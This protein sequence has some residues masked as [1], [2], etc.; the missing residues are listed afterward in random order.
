MTCGGEED[1]YHVNLEKDK[2]LI[3][4]FL[5]S[6]RGQHIIFI[7]DSLMRFQVFSLLY[8]IKYLHFMTED[9][10][11]NPMYRHGYATNHDFFV[12]STALFGP[13]SH[14]DC[15]KSEVYWQ[16]P[17]ENRYYYDYNYNFN[18]T[19]L[20]F[21]GEMEA[22]GHWSD[23][24]D[25]DH[26]RSPRESY[27]NPFWKKHLEAFFPHVAS[28]WIIP[29]T[30]TVFNVGIH[31]TD[32][33][34][35]KKW[36][37]YEYARMIVEAAQKHGPRFIFRTTTYNQNH[38][39]KGKEFEHFERDHLFCSMKGVKCQNVSWTRCIPIKDYI[40]DF[41]YIVEPYNRMA[42]QFMHL[43]LHYDYVS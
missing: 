18:I 27:L 14:C 17:L 21:Y 5:E 13:N 20:L 35:T 43:W 34:M 8:A 4:R 6:M 22:M 11:P 24:G 19:F 30:A 26:Y 15:Y 38:V 25:S 39:K 36:M 33:K 10:K 42:R 9:I 41:H 31:V 12:N 7:G 1:E 16:V 37:N 23:N 32:E 29:Y 28:R 40:D 2:H 3:N